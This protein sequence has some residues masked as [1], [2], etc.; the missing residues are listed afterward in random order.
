MAGLHVR[1]S[2]ASLMIAVKGARLPPQLHQE[3]PAAR[4]GD[5][6]GS[7]DALLQPLLPADRCWEQLQCPPAATDVSCN[8][9]QDLP[10]P[11]IFFPE[12]CFCVIACS[13]VVLEK[14]AAQHSCAKSSCLEQLLL[15]LLPVR[16]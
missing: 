11:W 1:N 16:A 7:E 13:V 5:P 3:P 6:S 8:T 14:P 10:S 15:M 4:P 2:L 9:Q 12:K